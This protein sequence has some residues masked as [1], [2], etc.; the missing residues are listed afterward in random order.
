[1]EYLVRLQVKIP[2]PFAVSCDVTIDHNTGNRIP[3]FPVCVLLT[4]GIE[5]SVVSLTNNLPRSAHPF[6]N[7]SWNLR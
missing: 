1:L 3:R 7:K 4:R 5:A 2:Y 6:E